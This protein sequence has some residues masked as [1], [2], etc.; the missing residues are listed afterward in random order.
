M[1]AECNNGAEYE[2]LAGGESPYRN[3]VAAGQTTGEDYE[4]QQAIAA[5]I[6]QQ[7]QENSQ[8]D[9]YYVEDFGTPEESVRKGG[10]PIGLKNVRNSK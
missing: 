2:K 6:K 3:A 7:E 1:K 10:E 8:Y 5:S 4:I 9:K